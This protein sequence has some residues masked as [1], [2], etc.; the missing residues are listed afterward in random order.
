MNVYLKETKYL[1]FNSNEIKDYLADFSSSD[2]QKETAIKLYYKVRDGFLYDPYHLDL[3]EKALK[4]STI[5]GKKRAWCCEKSILLASC[6]RFFSIPSRLGFAI[7]KNHIG[8][9]KLLTY[10]KKEEIVFHAY[11]E[12]YLNEKWVKCTPAFDK[13]VCL[14]SGVK[15]LVWDGENDSMFQEFQNDK[16]FMEYVYFYGEFDDVPIDLM[17]HEMKKHYPHLFEKEFHSKEF[18]FHHIYE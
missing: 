8:I 5:V 1:D 15:P 3:R 13:R 10:L 7:V 16:K 9:E 11:V 17:N 18:S 2:S 14:L 12:V 6:L 4:S